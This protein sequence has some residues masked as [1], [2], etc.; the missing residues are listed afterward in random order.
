MSS[1]EL[2]PADRI[3]QLSEEDQQEFIDSLSDDQASG[4]LYQ[5][6]GWSARP[7]QEIPDGLWSCLLYT[8]DAADE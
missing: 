7:A 2:S 8:S 4:L 3:A 5:W 1:L 6:S